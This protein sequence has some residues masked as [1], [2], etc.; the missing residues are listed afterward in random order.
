[1]A[2]Y[3]VKFGAG[4]HYHSEVQEAPDKTKLNLTRRVRV[5]DNIVVIPLRSIKRIG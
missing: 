3:R 5:G 4:E 1:M 2:T